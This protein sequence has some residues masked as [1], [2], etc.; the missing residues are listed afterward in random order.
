MYLESLERHDM[1]LAFHFSHHSPWAD[2]TINNT[3]TTR[4]HVLSKN[5]QGGVADWD[6]TPT[7]MLSI[8]VGYAAYLDSRATDGGGSIG[9]ITRLT[10]ESDD[11]RGWLVE[12]KGK[13]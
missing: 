12:R 1:H 13:C 7:S 2:P 3:Q 10:G 9:P 4:R 5:R 8:M 6:E 11:S